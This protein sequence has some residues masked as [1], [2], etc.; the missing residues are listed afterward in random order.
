MENAMILSSVNAALPSLM[1]SFTYDE[2][3]RMFQTPAYVTDRAAY[4]QGSRVSD[5]IAV[6]FNLAN[7]Y[8]YRFLNGVKIYGGDG[9]GKTKLLA[10][11]SFPMYQG[12]Y[13]SE[14]TGRQVAEN[15]LTSYIQN[16]CVVLGIPR[17][18]QE[19]ARQVAAK[20]VGETLLLT[21]KIGM[22]I[23]AGGHSAAI[24]G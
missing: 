23:T 3:D 19:Q 2:F 8:Y 6:V 22:Q 11:M 18:S 5:K 15:L 1:K 4:Y 10:E 20:M 16:Q 21:E 13:W 24:A 14:A 9:Q 12:A 7:G 17:P